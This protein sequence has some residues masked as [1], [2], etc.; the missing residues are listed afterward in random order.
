MKMKMKMRLLVSLSAILAFGVWV[1]TAVSDPSVGPPICSGAAETPIA[2]TYG[3][4]VITGNRY[5]PSGMTLNVWGNLTV[6]PGACLDAFTMGTVHVGHSVVV[7]NGAIL[8]L[9]CT[10]QS[11]FPPTPARGRR[12]TQSEGTST[13]TIR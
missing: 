3:N 4:L 2:G 13:E 9:G 6:F 10:L 1:G 11:T 8:A 7:G 5:V 12:T